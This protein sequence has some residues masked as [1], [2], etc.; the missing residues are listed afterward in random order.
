VELID[1]LQ[2]CVVDALTA[3]N[4]SRRFTRDFIGAGPWTVA[5]I[6]TSRVLCLTLKQKK[7]RRLGNG[8]P[9]P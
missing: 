3:G 2:I 8:G 1:L 7:D 4:G 5:S 9:F 6:I